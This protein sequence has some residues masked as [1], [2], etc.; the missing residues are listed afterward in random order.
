[1]H[2]HG[3]MIHATAAPGQGA[4]FGFTLLASAGNDRNHKG[5]P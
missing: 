5:P 3:G 1:V 4:T 2:R